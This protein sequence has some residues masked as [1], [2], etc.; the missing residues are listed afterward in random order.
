[1]INTNIFKLKRVFGIMY[2][3]LTLIKFFTCSLGFQIEEDPIIAIKIYPTIMNKFYGTDKYIK[4]Y[5]E[6]YKWYNNK[7][8]ISVVK[9]YSS[10]FL[11]G[12][13]DLVIYLWW[14]IT[15]L[16]VL[17]FILKIVKYFYCLKKE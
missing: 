8:Y 9:T 5:Q 10:L 11:N 14:I 2:F 1:M 13:Y 12:L 15:I 17:F 3:I 4:I 6:K 7:E 16:L